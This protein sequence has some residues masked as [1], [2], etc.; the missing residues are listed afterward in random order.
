VVD[1]AEPEGELLGEIEALLA[2][3]GR[4]KFPPALEARFEADTGERYCVVLAEDFKRAAVFYNL[5]TAGDFLLARDVVGVATA[6]HC[7]V[8]AALVA[9]ASILRRRRVAP[10]TRDI[11]TAAVP[12]LVTAQVMATFALSASP[13]ATHYLFF[14]PLNTATANSA[15]RVRH[16]AAAWATYAT[17]LLLPAILALTGKTPLPVAVMAMFSLGVCGTMTLRGMADREREFRRA[18]MHALRDRLRIAA[19]DAEAKRD[20]LTGA[21]NRRGLSAAA[22]AI[23]DGSATP[24]AA[25]LFDID[26]FKAYNDLYGHPAGDVCL[27]SI[28]ARAQALLSGRA[29]VLARYGG[30]EFLALLTGPVVAEAEAVAE[31]LR[32]AV[33]GLALPHAAA[34]GGF[35]SASFGVAQAVTDQTGFEALIAAADAALYRSKSAGRNKVSLAL[36]A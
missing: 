35:V 19:S 18:Y 6:L 21:A 9:M 7:A 4:L 26:R 11:A 8:V 27:K 30:E 14:V 20:A 10:L 32:R 33:L 15:M 3:R 36:A 2:Q 25:I 16:R 28:G 29:V 13:F 5:M 23:W 1:P 17:C 34:E 22:R 12:F 24:V 31:D